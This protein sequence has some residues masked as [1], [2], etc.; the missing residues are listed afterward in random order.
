VFVTKDT[1]TFI[2]ILT[3]HVLSVLTKPI[4]RSQP[5]KVLQEVSNGFKNFVNVFRRILPR[6]FVKG[7]VWTITILALSS[8]Q[9]RS[10]LI[11]TLNQFHTLTFLLSLPQFIVH[12]GQIKGM[13]IR[14]RRRKQLQ[15][16]LNEKKICLLT[17]LLHG[18][19]SFLR[20]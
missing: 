3:C 18:A 19:E 16:D 7:K 6:F 15:D 8:Y 4:Y 1:F 13:V 5:G 10:I 17:Y 14:G 11:L 20:S 12:Q 2:H 9:I